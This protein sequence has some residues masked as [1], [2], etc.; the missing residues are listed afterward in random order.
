MEE[1]TE[2]HIALIFATL[3]IVAVIVYH[4]SPNKLPWHALTE[5]AWG[6]AMPHPH[7]RGV[8]ASAT[9]LLTPDNTA[10]QDRLLKQCY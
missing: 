8:V 7:V 3:Q 1:L 5:S 9:K 2:G 10:L 6:Q 4:S